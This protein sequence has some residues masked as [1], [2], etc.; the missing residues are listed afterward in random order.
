MISIIKYIILQAQKLAV[1]VELLMGDIPDRSIFRQA[2]M[3]KTLLPYLQLTQGI[4]NII[5]CKCS[6]LLLYHEI[7]LFCPVC[8][9]LGV[10]H[11]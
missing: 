10:T 5:T 8:N 7:K 1:V 6:L 2:T 4:V 3:R 9:S 11:L